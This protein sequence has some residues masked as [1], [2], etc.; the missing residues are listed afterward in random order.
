MDGTSVLPTC[1][2]ARAVSNN[3]SGVRRGVRFARFTDADAAFAP[4]AAAI[5]PA[6]P[7]AANAVPV[8]LRRLFVLEAGH[9]DYPAQSAQAEALFVEL[10]DFFA[11][12]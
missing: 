5:R 6:A 7:A 3:G 4:G 9:F 2:G 8:A 12:L 11:G 10:E 1:R